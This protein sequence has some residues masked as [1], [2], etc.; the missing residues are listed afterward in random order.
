[1]I[2]STNSARFVNTTE[3]ITGK[4]VNLSSSQ[5]TEFLAFK[6]AA[7]CRRSGHITLTINGLAY[8]YEDNMTLNLDLGITF[9]GSITY[10]Y[11][12]ILDRVLMQG[13]TDFSATV[14]IP[15]LTIPTM[16]DRYIYAT[17]HV[18]SFTAV[19]KTLGSLFVDADQVVTMGFSYN[20][21]GVPA[22]PVHSVVVYNVIAEYKE[23]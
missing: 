3:D 1:M 22:T 19:H 5:T 13:T 16:D 9:P 15:L 10:A 12:I 4:L 6:P 21:P 7:V 14:N 18:G 8:M 20:I 17:S 23:N 2:I 11:P